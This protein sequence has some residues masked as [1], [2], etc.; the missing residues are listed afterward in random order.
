ML[1]C[2]RGD[3]YL[4]RDL[5]IL[6][7]KNVVKVQL[8]NL[9]P[10][11][12]ALDCPDLTPELM[13]AV[14]ARYS[15]NNE[16]LEAILG[17]ID[18]TAPDKSVDSIFRMVD[19][20]HASI[21]DMVPVALF[22]DN[23]S[24]LA[25]MYL[26]YISPTASGQ[27]SSTR[28]IRYDPK[29]I[30]DSEA[31]GLPKEELYAAQW[32]AF[33]SYEG[34]HERWMNL[35][36][37]E[38]SRMKIPAEVIE[39]TSEKGKAKLARMRNNYA[40]D[41][42]RVFLPLS[43]CTNMMMIQSA[44]AWVDVISHMMSFPLK[45]FQAIGEALKEQLEKAAPRMVKHA[46]P[47]AST[48]AI[49]EDQLENIMGFYE[50]VKEA[51]FKGHVYSNVALKKNCG[52]KIQIFSRLGFDEELFKKRE[53]RYSGFDSAVRLTPV[54][55][56]WTWATIGEIRDLNRHRTGEKE[57]SFIPNGFYSAQEE[58]QENAELQ[59]YLLEQYAGSMAKNFGRCWQQLGKGDYSGLYY[60]S[61]G[62]TMSFAH[63]TTLNKFIYEMELRTGT[64]A[65]YKYSQMMNELYTEMKNT[66]F[67]SDWVNHI[68]IG[69]AEPE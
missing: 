1:F 58:A 56:S 2:V 63:T 26:W 47:K 8:V 23:I 37:N 7:Y 17:K 39:D 11:D 64:G 30:L 16:G 66:A 48:K 12:T 69:Q 20:G 18:F 46:L 5:G 65:H 10:P 42:A 34:A 13:A 60:L 52:G 21:G 4:E 38:P 40:F 14:G 41:R 44:R 24:L 32:E 51:I 6:K 55:F 35:G 59:K 28:Y 53:N 36:K 62:H 22:I 3:R 15:R 45:E 50:I 25:A 29:K 68:Q 61:L 33:S 27:E 54:R 9:I 31:C 57:I 49:I 67:M 43:S 19:Y